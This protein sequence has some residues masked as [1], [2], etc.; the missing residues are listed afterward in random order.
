VGL[1][2]DACVGLVGYAAVLCLGALIAFVVPFLVVTGPAGAPF[3][4]GLASGVAGDVGAACW[5]VHGWRRRLAAEHEAQD[6]QRL[7]EA[8]LLRAETR[9]GGG[10]PAER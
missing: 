4:A 3:A 8:H 9:T 7:V 5:C 10:P 1:D 6:Q 2:V